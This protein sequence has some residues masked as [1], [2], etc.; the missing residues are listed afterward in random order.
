MGQDLARGIVPAAAL[1]VLTLAGCSAAPDSGT[2]VRDKSAKQPSQSAEAEATAKGA[3]IGRTGTPCVL[4]VSFTTAADWTAEKVKAGDDPVFGS[5]AR[6]GTVKLVCEIDAKPTGY[7]GYLRVWTGDDAGTPRKVLEGFMAEESK[8]TTVRYRETKAGDLPATEVTYL[9]TTE[10]ADEP[11]KERALAVS[12]PRGAVV[13]HLGGLDTW[14]HEQMLPAYE[15]AKE[16]M[17]ATG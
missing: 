7:I 5:I 11:K 17:V 3:S 10:L 6:Q 2:A 16:T 15:L 1:A 12:T 8:A 14:E 4:P 9:R 13:L